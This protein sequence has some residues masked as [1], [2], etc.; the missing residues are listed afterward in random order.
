MGWISSVLPERIACA[1]T[2]RRSF[3]GAAGELE[4]PQAL[5]PKLLVGA[6]ALRLH[7]PEDEPELL[8]RDRPPRTAAPDIDLRR[9]LAPDRVELARDL[10]SDL[11]REELRL[12][13]V[14]C[15][16]TSL[17]LLLPDSGDEIGRH[18]R[19]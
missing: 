16:E 1:S 10:Q 4:V 14:R 13:M 11:L 15:L 12:P 8:I 18:A 6:K 17:D 19:R 7:G 2:S 3:K 9:K 5:D